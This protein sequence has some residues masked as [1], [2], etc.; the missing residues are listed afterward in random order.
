MVHGGTERDRRV[1]QMNGRRVGECIGEGGKTHPAIALLEAVI[2]NEARMH[3]HALNRG[4]Q[5]TGSQK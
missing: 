5:I 2:E 1:N 4:I 3:T